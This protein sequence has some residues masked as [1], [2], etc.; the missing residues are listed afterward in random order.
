MRGRRP[1]ARNRYHGGDSYQTFVGIRL[2]LRGVLTK[3]DVNVGDSLRSDIEGFNLMIA[4]ANENFEHT[5]VGLPLYQG[6]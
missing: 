5:G 3:K 4:H 2:S 1:Q 6:H